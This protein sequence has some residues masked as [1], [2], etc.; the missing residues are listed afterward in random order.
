MAAPTGCKLLDKTNVKRLL[1]SIDTVLTDCDGVIYHGNKAVPGAAAA[2]LKLKKLGKR[3]F[4]V[5]NNSMKTRKEFAQK[6]S[7]LGFPAT[8]DD[9]VGSGYVVAQTLQQKYKYSGK[10]YT[11]GSPSLAWELSQVGITAVG[12]GPDG[13]S[14]KDV[15]HF[16]LDKDVKCV[17]CGFDEHISYA[18]IAKAMAYLQHKEC[19]FVVTNTDTGLPSGSG[20]LLPGAGSMVAML[21]TASQRQPDVICGKP[22]QPMF[23]VLLN[24]YKLTPKKTLMIGDRLDTDI[25]LAGRCSLQSLLVLTGFSTLDEVKQKQS[26]STAD[27]QKQIPDYYLP[28]LA[29][30]GTLLD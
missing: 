10:A 29:D 8:E 7:D 5:T 21:Q 14:M 25:L 2:V 13:T 4:Y 16:P 23:D 19:L 9:I 11:L 12:I 22:N 15:E 17:I 1:D 24:K 30:L 3:F 6:C 20:R 26:S 28:S 27:D 18:K